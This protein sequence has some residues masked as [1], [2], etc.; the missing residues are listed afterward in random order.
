MGFGL[1][2]LVGGYVSDAFDGKFWGIILLF[3]IL[4]AITFALSTTL[5]FGELEEAKAIVSR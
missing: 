4:G 3:L 5:T 2:T 1:T